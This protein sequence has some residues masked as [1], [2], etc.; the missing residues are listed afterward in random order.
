VPDA[1]KDNIPDDIKEKAREMARQEL[2]RRLEELDMSP[3]EARTYGELL[4][5]TQT[6]GICYHYMICLNVS[7]YASTNVLY[8]TSICHK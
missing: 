4:V 7:L 1:L 5:A 6:Y 8:L 2:Q 3:A